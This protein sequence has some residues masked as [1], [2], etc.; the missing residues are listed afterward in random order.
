ML[1][2][3]ISWLLTALYD[4]SGPYVIKKLCSAL[5]THFRHYC[6]LWPNCISHLAHC[7]YSN[8]SLLPSQ[9]SFSTIEIVQSLTPEKSRSAIW[10]CMILAEEA[11]RLLQS[12]ST[13]S[14]AVL[15]CMAG[16]AHDAKLLMAHFLEVPSSPATLSCQQ[17]AMK[18]LHPWIIYAQKASK[19]PIIEE[20]QSLIQSVI[21]CLVVD[22]LYGPAIQLLTDT[23]E[24]WE[25]FFTPNHINTLYSFFESPWAQQRYQGL[26]QGDFDMDSVK[27]GVFLLAFA[28]AQQSQLMDMTSDR[29]LSFLGGLTNLL[30]IDCSF[31]D[32]EIFVQALEFWGQFVE[33]LSMEYLSDSFEWDQ[34]PLLQIRDVLSSAWR[35][36]QF[37]DP[38]VFNSWDSSE[39][40]AFSE[41][42]KDLADLLQYVH[43]MTGRPL[44]SLFADSILLALEKANWAEVEAATFCLGALSDC[45]SEKETNDDILTRVFGSPLFD[46]LRQTQS[47][48][49]SRV[50]RTC[51]SLVERYSDYFGRNEIYLEPALNLLFSAVEDPHLAISASKSIYKLCSSCRYHFTSQV[52]AFIEHYSNLRNGQKLESLPE[53]RIVG[54]IACIIQAVPDALSKADS[55]RRLLL[56][57]NIDIDSCMQLR[58]CVPGTVVAVDNPVSSVSFLYILIPTLSGCPYISSKN[59]SHHR[60]TITNAP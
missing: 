6:L 33:S 58:S 14:I 44:V 38:D 34:P 32:D 36:L 39:R 49:P 17:A 23:L 20:L 27:F 3:I 57:I 52:N 16:N 4:G 12:D 5:V 25:H 35:K 55:F 40:N 37:P 51:L 46:L 47:T 15:E 54:A 42:R 1:Q 18:C 10:F 43:T 29:T 59:E 45:I 7:L 11:E 13:H 30:K 56:I 28:N 21:Q 60:R 24:D 9:N 26:C 31:A 8:Q 50:R 19:R 53:E 41:A 2:N 22:D 48:L